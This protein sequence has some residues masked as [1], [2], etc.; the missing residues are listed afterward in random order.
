MGLRGVI[1]HP[2][3]VGDDEMLTE[4]DESVA[5]SSSFCAGGS[6]GEGGS[7]ER[8]GERKGQEVGDKT[9]VKNQYA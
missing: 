5:G 8:V 7:G 1:E 3:L 6:G 4:K 2:L 9:D